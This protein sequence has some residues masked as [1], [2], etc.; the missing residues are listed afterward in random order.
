MRIVMYSGGDASENEEVDRHLFE[1][2][3]TIRP[4]ITFIPTASYHSRES[5]HEFIGHY[6]QYGIRNFRMLQVDELYS[7]AELQEALDVDIVYFGGGNTYHLL[8]AIRTSDFY[9][10]LRRFLHEDGV[11]AG[12]SA[13]AIVMTPTIYT[14]AIPEFDADPNDIGLQDLT[15]MGLV[16]FEFFPHYVNE[17]RYDLP[18]LEYSRSVPYPI[19]ACPDGSG[20]VSKRGEV[21]FVGECYGFHAGRKFVVVGEPD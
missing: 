17:Q 6:K 13:G 10:A 7:A 1:L 11:V 18:F 2:A 14:A 5:F 8:D 20:I 15:G 12:L 9:P 16:P 3:G 4:K 19:Y 21:T